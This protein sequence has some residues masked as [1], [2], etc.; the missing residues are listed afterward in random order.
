MAHQVR[1]DSPWAY[2]VHVDTF[3]IFF[4]TPSHFLK[5]YVH[6]FHKSPELPFL[7]LQALLLLNSLLRCCRSGTWWPGCHLLCHRLCRAQILLFLPLYKPYRW[8]QNVD[9]HLSNTDAVQ[10]TKE[11]QPTTPIGKLKI[12]SVRNA[13]EAANPGGSPARSSRAFA[14]QAACPVSSGLGMCCGSPHCPAV[15]VLR[16]TSLARKKIKHKIRN[17]MSA[18]R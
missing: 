2:C 14:A 3:Q 15:H 9:A 10:L 11:L 17:R 5:I 16:V 7:L 1:R 6:D 8:Q 12:P 18:N 13:L 4:I